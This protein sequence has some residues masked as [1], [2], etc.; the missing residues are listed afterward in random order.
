MNKIK[1]GWASFKALPYLF[2]MAWWGISGA[3]I[4]SLVQNC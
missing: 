3:I 4:V 2:Q 1:E